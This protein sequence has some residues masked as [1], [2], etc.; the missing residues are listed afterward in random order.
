M[1]LAEL[2]L[3]PGLAFSGGLCHRIG[4]EPALLNRLLNGSL[5][6]HRQCA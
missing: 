2:G 6:N 4:L 5:V 3:G 1:R